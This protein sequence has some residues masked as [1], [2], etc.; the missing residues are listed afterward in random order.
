MSITFV[1][2]HIYEYVSLFLHYLSVFKT[3]SSK[4]LSIISVLLKNRKYSEINIPVIL[5]YAYFVS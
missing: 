4:N 2:N 5:Q 1:F 3:T